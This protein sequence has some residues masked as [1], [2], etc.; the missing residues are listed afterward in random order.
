MSTTV[1]TYNDKVL[2]NS[3]NDKWLKKK[4][5]PAGFVMNASNAIYTLVGN[6]YY[7]AWEG[8]AYPD[9]YNGNGKQYILVNSN[10]VTPAS[11]NPLTYGNGLNVPGPNAIAGS[12]MYIQGTT[13]GVLLNNAAFGTYGNYIVW[14]A[15]IQA[16]T[17]EETEAYMAN[18]SITIVDP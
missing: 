7:I 12:D 8:P 3:A 9:G 6:S 17:L 18:V 4:E 11:L 1:Y 14:P 2:V 10:T 13:T 16:A 15:P 5:A